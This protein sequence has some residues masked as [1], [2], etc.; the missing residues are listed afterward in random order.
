MD[1]DIFTA[2]PLNMPELNL[3]VPYRA[4]SPATSCRFSADHARTLFILIFSMNAFIPEFFQGFR[5]NSHSMVVIILAAYAQQKNSSRAQISFRRLRVQQTFK[6]SYLQLKNSSTKLYTSPYVFLLLADH[7]WPLY[8]F[9]DSLPHCSTRPVRN[10][11]WQQQIRPPLSSLP[12]RGFG[13]GLHPFNG[14]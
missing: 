12:S 2:P 8:N 1:K 3:P 9:C 13:L 14:W 5:A 10:F 6:L 11:A 7:S 4:R